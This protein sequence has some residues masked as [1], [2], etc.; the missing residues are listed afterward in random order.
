MKLEIK[1]AGELNWWTLEKCPSNIITQ[2]KEFSM[3]SELKFKLD[4]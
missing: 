4:R 3:D 1:I 2:A